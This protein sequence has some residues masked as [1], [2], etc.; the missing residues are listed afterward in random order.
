MAVY[1][2]DFSIML[3]TEKSECFFK[4]DLSSETISPG[5]TYFAILG[6][7]YYLT[8]LVESIQDHG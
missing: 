5:R 3:M 4:I 8:L 7:K 6:I 1:L 2:D